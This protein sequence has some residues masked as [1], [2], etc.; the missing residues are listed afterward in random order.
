MEVE[1]Q[2]LPRYQMQS[3]Q[4]KQRK[5]QNFRNLIWLA[6]IEHQEIEGSV[7]L[8]SKEQVICFQPYVTIFPWLSLPSSVDRLF[9]D[10]V[11]VVASCM[12]VVPFQRLSS[13]GASLSRYPIVPI[14][15]SLH[16]SS[17]V[18]LDI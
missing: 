15:A 14:H 7:Q 12:S 9:L 16:N 13:A 11:Q 10:R 6:S 3:K 8:K 17:R 4:N 18:F 1:G 5:A 2:S